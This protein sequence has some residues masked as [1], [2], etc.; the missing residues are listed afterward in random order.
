MNCDEIVCVRGR[1]DVAGG[2]R[3][4]RN[5]GSHIGEG[6]FEWVSQGQRGV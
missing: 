6:A 2:V 4:W 5:D 1:G 3:G